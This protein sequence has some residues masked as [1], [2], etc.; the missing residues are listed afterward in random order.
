[1]PN[2]FLFEL[3][4]LNFESMFTCGN[5]LLKFNNLILQLEA[6]TFL[7]GARRVSN[8]LPFASPKLG[9]RL[10]P[11]DVISCCELGLSN[12]II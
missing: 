7:C 6:Q 8:K 5:Y 10:S 9:D 2:L 12:K 11:R 4:R 3:A 1:M